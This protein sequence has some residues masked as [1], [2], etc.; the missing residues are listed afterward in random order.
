[1]GDP[2]DAF[3]LLRDYMREVPG[4][5]QAFF[6]MGRAYFQQGHLKEAAEQLQK[7]AELKPDNYAVQYDYGDVLSHLGDLQGAIHVLRAAEKLAPEK[8]GAPDDL[9]FIFRKEGKLQLAQQEIAAFQKAKQRSQN[10]STAAALGTKANQALQRGNAKG[11]VQEYE[12]ALSFDPD[13]GKMHYDLGLALGKLGRRQEEQAELQKVIEL[14]ANLAEAHN[15]LG[16][17]LM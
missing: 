2:G 3:L 14:D 7:A 13:N 9:S 15:E 10:V 6:A 5:Y 17:L 4:N 16:V 1:M 11:A 12:R 8:S